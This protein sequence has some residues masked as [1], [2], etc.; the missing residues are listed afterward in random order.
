MTNSLTY[1]HKTLR[2]GAKAY[3]AP[4]I[5][6]QTSHNNDGHIIRRPQDDG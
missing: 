4:E 6:A 5:D 3:K 2:I 1:E